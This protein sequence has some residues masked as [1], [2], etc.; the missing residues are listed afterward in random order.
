MKLVY[1]TIR[2]GQ[3]HGRKPRMFKRVKLRKM[4]FSC[5]QT[6]VGSLKSSFMKFGHYVRSRITCGESA[7]YNWFPR[8]N[9]PIDPRPTALPSLSA[10]HIFDL[11]RAVREEIHARIASHALCIS[12]L[13]ANTNSRRIYF[14]PI[15]RAYRYNTSTLY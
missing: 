11:F 6:F 1:D 3:A 9:L 10:S 4:R 2:I 12:N 13:D 14:D 5:F 8:Q 7:P 15:Y